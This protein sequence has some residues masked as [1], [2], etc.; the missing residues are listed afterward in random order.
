MGDKSGVNV[1][2]NEKLVECCKNDDWEA[3]WDCLKQGANPDGV[4]GQRSSPLEMAARADRL[5]VVEKLLASGADA[6]LR[7]QQE[8]TP[9]MGAIV[10]GS[11]RCLAALLKAGADARA[12]GEEGMSALHLLSSAKRNGDGA[13]KM[14]D[15][16]G[17][18]SVGICWRSASRGRAPRC[19]WPRPTERP[20]RWRR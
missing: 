6:N 8:F 18:S 17:E 9:M 3:V 16:L 13:R 14:A 20:T 7:S 1:K 11:R 5:A 19:W 10:G 4:S 15:A 2:A 12:L